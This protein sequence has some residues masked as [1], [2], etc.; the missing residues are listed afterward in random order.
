VKR[1]GGKRKEGDL[2]ASQVFSR[3]LREVRDFHGWTQEQL[4]AYLRAADVKVSQETIAKLEKE[5]TRADHLTVNE[6]F[7]ICFALNVSPIFMTVPLDEHEPRLFISKAVQPPTPD[8]ARAWLRGRKELDG[9]NPR[10]FA[11]QRPEKE[12]AEALAELEA[13]YVG[14]ITSAWRPPKAES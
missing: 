2:T 10:T 1:V 9:Q 5:T 12:R 8:E 7:A 11:V 6:L 14:E 13:S 3:R 4:A